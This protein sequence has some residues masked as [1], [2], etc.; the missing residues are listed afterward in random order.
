MNIL[1]KRLTS[2]F[3]SAILLAIITSGLTSNIHFAE[4]ASYYTVST[5]GTTFTAKSPTGTTLYSGSNAAS[6]ISKAI[7]SVPVGGTVYIY[8]GTYPVSSQIFGYKNSVTVTGDSTAVI[9]ATVTMGYIFVWTGSSTK[10]LTGF[11]LTNIVFDGNL[12]SA[13]VSVKWVDNCVIQGVTVKNTAKRTTVSGFD[14]KGTS[15]STVK[16]ITVTGCKVSNIY[17]SGVALS[18][19]TDSKINSNT[20]V[21]CA[22]YYPSGGAVLGDAGC[23]RI[24]I[25]YNNISGRSDNDGIYMGTS[26]SFASG[27]IITDNTIN[28]KLYGTGGGQYLA[29]SGIKVYTLNSEIGRNTI[30]W[31]NTPWVYG[32]Q[33]WGMGNNVH[34]NKVTGARVGYGCLTG[35]YNGKSTVTY[36]KIYTCYKGVDIEQKYSYVSGNVLTSCTIDLEIVSGNTVTG[37]TIN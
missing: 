3:I 31:N 22:Q 29:G 7:S 37:N 2:V 30:N 17:A 32:V 12:K 26:R 5:N 27:C 15:G 8:G 21:D 23:Q 24:T 28:L 10:H 6:A 16:G 35:Y 34:D 1:S 4:A 19:V 25:Q 36:N 14:I 9:K 13:G 20:F 11:K 33:N 18:Y